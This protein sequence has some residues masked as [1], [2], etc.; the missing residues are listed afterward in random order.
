MTVINTNIAALRAAA[1]GTRNEVDMQTAM[2][3][4]STSKRINSAADDAA[5]MAIAA[6]MAAS[7]AGYNQG[8]RNANDGI[9]LV[10]TVESDMAAVTGAL[11]RM[12][13]LSVQ[14]YNGTNGTND[15]AS[16]GTEYVAMLNEI[17]RISGNS[18]FNGIAMNTTSAVIFAVG[19]G[20]AA[21]D[22]ITLTN[23]KFDPTTLAL[24]STMTTGASAATAIP[25]LD[26]ALAT[27]GTARANL[28]ATQNRLQVAVT[29]A[30]SNATNLSAARS[31]IEDTDYAVETTNLARGQILAQAGT[32]M[33]AQA[34]Q[35]GQSVLA[36]L[37]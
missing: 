5:G 7:I 2:Q 8:V 34:N 30:Q 24:Q 18:A 29:A 25:L 36:L 14:A 15:L 6:K 31:R 23:Q 4:L 37:K 12:R 19:S 35:Q 1:A 33:L 10:Q 26:A 9:S 21:T 3:R 20:A 32:A 11:Q 28:G 22:L 13:V 16:L 17:T 27:V